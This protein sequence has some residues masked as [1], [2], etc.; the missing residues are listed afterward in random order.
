M[1]ANAYVT[2]LSQ[3]GAPDRNGDVSASGDDAWVG[4]CPAYLRRVRTRVMTT[5]GDVGDGSQRIQWS[6]VFRDMLV[7]QSPPQALLA[8]VP[9]DDAQGWTVVVEDRRPIA[10]RTSRFRVVTV[11]HRAAGTRVDS[12]RLELDDEQTV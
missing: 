3:P 8:A 2:A 7:V 1:L 10:Q 4:R 6:S 5:R 12:L 11:D 9:G